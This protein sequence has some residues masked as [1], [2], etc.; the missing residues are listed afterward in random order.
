[1]L[2][3]PD[4]EALLAALVNVLEAARV[5]VDDLVRDLASDHWPGL[6]PP[7]TP[8]TGGSHHEC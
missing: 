4:L 3:D 5:T 8:L 2:S 6:S 7:A 1:M